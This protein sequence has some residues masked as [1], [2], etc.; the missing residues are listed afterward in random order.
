MVQ[1]THTHTHTH[2]LYF[3]GIMSLAASRHNMH[4]IYTNCYIYIYTVP[5]DDE[6]AVLKTCTGR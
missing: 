4:K 6:Q 3:I 2:K 1:V 5:P